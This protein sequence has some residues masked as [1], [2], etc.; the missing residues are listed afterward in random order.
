MTDACCHKQYSLSSSSTSSSEKKKKKNRYKFICNHTFWKSY[1][2][3][4]PIS[5]HC[6]NRYSQFLRISNCLIFQR[7]TDIFI[8]FLNNNSQMFSLFCL[9]YANMK[10]CL[11]TNFLIDGREAERKALKK[12]KLKF[13][14]QFFLFW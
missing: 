6:S 2:S 8:F 7:Y 13:S 14:F 1:M 4:L 3:C 9:L 10:Q 12:I 11:Q 5:F